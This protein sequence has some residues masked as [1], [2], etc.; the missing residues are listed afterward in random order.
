MA[1]VVLLAVLV[2]ISFSI[3]LNYYA[4]MPGSACV[5]NTL[6]RASYSAACGGV[7]LVT[8]P[9]G[10]DHPSRGEIL[11]TDVSLS[12]VRLVDFIP[13]TL[14]SDTQVVSANA[15]LGSTPPS[16]LGAQDA[17]AM[18]DSTLSARVAALR[19][20]GYAVGITPGGAIINQVEPG[21]PADGRLQ[22]GDVVT[23]VDGQS[24][25]S[26][27]DV[28]TDTRRH[29]PGQ[30]IHLRVHPVDGSHARNVAITLGA[31]RDHGKEV[32][33]IGVS[34]EAHNSYDLPFPV[35][36]DSANIG[37]PSAGL[38]FAL[39][40][41]QELTPGDITG[42]HRISATGTIAPDGSVGEIGGVAQKADAARAAGATVFLVPSAN[43][44]Q[45][46]AHAGPHLRVISVK[47]LDDAL[48]ALGAAGGNVRS[49]PAPPAT[50]RG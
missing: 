42:D 41:V 47:S 26:A 48:A 25:P 10:M 38:A 9:A 29:S 4:L 5:V 39:A 13:D 40:I 7:P 46:K 15:I 1:V 33:F 24:T 18:L 32:A 36:I 50:S 43:Y 49:L 44:A 8:V 17:L 30:V 16:Q 14:R 19:R 12:R 31:H 6:V 20:L 28:V 2:G 34:L 27:D 22:V 3:Q 37:G 11:L 35:K 45:A 21:S 23:S